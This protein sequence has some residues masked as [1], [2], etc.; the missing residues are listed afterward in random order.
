[1]Q[2]SELLVRTIVTLLLESGRVGVC[3]RR[4]LDALCV[5]AEVTSDAL[6][7]MLRDVASSGAR[8]VTL[9][10]AWSE[11]LEFFRHLVD[12]ASVG[13]K[14][15]P[16]MAGVLDAVTRRIR[17]FAGETEASLEAALQQ[18][19]P[20][21]QADTRPLAPPGVRSTAP[22]GA[23]TSV[24]SSP[25]S[26]AGPAPDGTL[27][28]VGD[29]GVR[30]SRDVELLR[31]AFW[32]LVSDGRLTAR[33]S[34]FLGRLAERLGLDVREVLQP[35]EAS[36]E[37]R[38]GEWFDRPIDERLEAFQVLLDAAWTDGCISETE[39]VQLSGLADELD[40][41]PVE[42]PRMV[43]SGRAVHRWPPLQSGA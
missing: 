35:S 11:R 13:G 10:L 2:P 34:E 38:L 19:A 7:R 30:Q 37:L 41:D 18:H 21:R 24:L 12:A 39:R 17:V 16:E 40:L 5:R 9:P 14:V 27:V 33:E 1:M 29:L 43:D 22:P 8:M 20:R 31:A 15:A 26:A 4:L 25:G 42:V 23:E 36:G 3:E 6:D 32:V 28:L